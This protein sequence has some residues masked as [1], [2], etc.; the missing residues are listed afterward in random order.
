MRDS[1]AHHLSAFRDGGGTSYQRQRH[2]NYLIKRCFC[3]ERYRR[4]TCISHQ[5]ERRSKFSKIAAHQRSESAT[6]Q[7]LALAAHHLSESCMR[8]VKDS[9]AHQVSAIIDSGAASY[10]RQRRINHLRLL[11]MCHQRQ[12]KIIYERYR[13]TSLI[14]KQRQRR[15]KLSEHHKISTINN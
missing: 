14:S 3:H 5:N 1:S 11:L 9:G 12:L 2:I 13:G 7:P 8:S 15:S 10:Q 4:T 6:H